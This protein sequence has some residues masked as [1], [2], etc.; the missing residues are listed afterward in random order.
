MNAMNRRQ[1]LS[2]T[3]MGVGTAAIFFPYVGQVLGANERINVACIGVGGKG[4]SDSSDAAKCGGNI[5]ALCD[6]DKNT[7][8]RKLKQ[9]PQAK[10]YQ[11]YRKLLDEMGK[12][13]DAVTVST[14]DHNHGIA[15]IRAMKMGKHCFCQKPLT[16]N[17]EEARIMRQLSKEKKLATQ[18][19]NQGSAENGLRRAVEVIHAGVI[20]KPL[21]LHVWSNR[22]VWPQGYDRPAGSDPVPST[23]DWDLWLGP[24]AM[25]PFKQGCYHTFAW[26]GW[27]DFGTGA[28]GDMA[29]HTVNMPFRALKLGFPTLVECELA[30]R[31]YPET[32]P[33]TS[34][35]RFEFP[36]REGLPPLKFW[37]YDGNPS[38]TP[39][40]PGA[41]K[42]EK[43][44]PLRP[45][46]GICKEIIAMDNMPGSGA[47]IVGEKG[48]IFSPDDY[49]AQF[50]MIL[51]GE[52]GFMSGDKHE[53][54]KAIPQS[55]PRS[56]GHMQEWFR[57]MKEGTPSYSNF[58]IAAYLTEIILLGCIALRVGEGY[59]MEWDGPN[60]KSTNLPQ[61]A[62]FVSRKNRA[63]WNV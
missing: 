14:P 38:G 36:E 32:F 48:K 17:V 3:S 8:D 41:G 30:S 7:L 47:L 6:V 28:L 39:V 1:F 44:K 9:F 63:G 22:P 42:R 58:D 15:A 35:I 55:I 50:Y 34:R 26:R 4:D 45:D 52:E 23:L 57:M 13:I 46:A 16:Q 19:G 51:K 62:Q 54:C 25:R 49:G 33:E 2:R 56:P 53:A 40:P 60:M 11:D 29:C 59:R 12:D 10:G 37:W 27:Y 43:I 61:A 24:A 20:G 31:V 18:M 21:E 5:V